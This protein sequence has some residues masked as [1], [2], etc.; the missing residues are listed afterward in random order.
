MAIE[1]PLQYNVLEALFSGVD[2]E[3]QLIL[4]DAVADIVDKSDL[5]FLLTIKGHQDS[6]LREKATE[7]IKE[8]ENR[9]GQEEGESESFPDGHD[10]E[11]KK[12]DT[13]L[14]NVQFEVGL[15]KDGHSDSK[16]KQQI[17]SKKST[18]LEQLLTFPY[19]I[20]QSLNG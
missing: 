14:F 7:I 12:D 11:I 1:V 10:I 20:I 8:L 18:V 19:K 3:E 9:L 17:K 16:N 6:K 2:L 15:P 5:P 13:D 4:L